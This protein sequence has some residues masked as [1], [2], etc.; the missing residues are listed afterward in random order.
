MMTLI[1]ILTLYLCLFAFLPSYS[2][3]I[4]NLLKKL[5]EGFSLPSYHTCYL[6][7]EIMAA[8]STSNDVLTIYQGLVSK[9]SLT[10]VHMIVIIN[11]RIQMQV[12]NF[13]AY[14][15]ERGG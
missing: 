13:V 1:S 5:S 10:L 3:N 15:R 2:L 12:Y 14:I 4:Y 7:M 6:M 9:I 11:L 8:I